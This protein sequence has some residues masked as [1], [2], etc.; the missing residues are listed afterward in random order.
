MDEDDSGRLTPPPLPSEAFRKSLIGWDA[1]IES[2]DRKAFSLVLRSVARACLS[3]CVPD[4][5]GWRAVEDIDVC[6]VG[7]AIKK[8]MNRRRSSPLV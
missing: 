8:P 3:V 7:K 5:D 1:G 4:V 2:S 6:W